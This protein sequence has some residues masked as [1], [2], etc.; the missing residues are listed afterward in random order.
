MEDKK[1]YIGCDVHK[2]YSVLRVMDER[3]TL[4]PS[5]KVKHSDGELE[6]VL[7]S[8]PPGS[9]VAVLGTPVSSPPGRPGSRPPRSPGGARG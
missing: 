5:M 1:Q 7:R 6:R 4:G 8:F 9:P 3:G 2:D